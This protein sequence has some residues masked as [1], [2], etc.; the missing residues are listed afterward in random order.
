MVW[1][2]SVAWLKPA[3]RHPLFFSAPGPARTRS[4]AHCR[5]ARRNFYTNRPVKK[6]CYKQSVPHLTEPPIN[7][8][9]VMTTTT[10]NKSAAPSASEMDW[11]REESAVDETDSV[12]GTRTFENRGMNALAID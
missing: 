3:G 7:Q 12:A 9:K 2:C 11:K 6:S 5:R 4:A 10:I 1:H 8:G